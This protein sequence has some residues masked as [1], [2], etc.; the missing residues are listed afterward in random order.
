MLGLLDATLEKQRLLA[1]TPPIKEN[2]HIL[3]T[4]TTVSSCP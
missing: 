2:I 3:K 1:M 4:T